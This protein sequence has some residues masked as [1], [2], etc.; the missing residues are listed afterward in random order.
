MKPSGLIALSPFN[1]P[2][3]FNT[4]HV[5]LLI[6]HRS[7]SSLSQNSQT[8]TFPFARLFQI[9]P[10]IESWP[11]IPRPQIRTRSS[12]TN[13]DRRSFESHKKKKKTQK[14]TNIQRR[15]QSGK[16][17][18]RKAYLDK[19]ARLCGWWGGGVC[20]G[21]WVKPSSSIVK[22]VDEN[23]GGVWT[24]QKINVIFGLYFPLCTLH[25]WKWIF[26]FFFNFFGVWLWERVWYFDSTLL[27]SDQVTEKRKEKRKKKCKIW[28]R[29]RWAKCWWRLR[30]QVREKELFI[31]FLFFYESIGCC[32]HV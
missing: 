19:N 7:N 3:R 8:T 15:N 24:P 6:F 30:L 20:W 23:G 27:E 1:A 17:R 18:N 31:V 21:S 4:R 12:G 28:E 5:W 2:R 16:Q 13:P 32:I 26:F 11:R 9:E 14:Q 22:E 29:G 10:Q 25:K